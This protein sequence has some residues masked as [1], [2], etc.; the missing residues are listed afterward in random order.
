MA[1]RT[2]TWHEQDLV[3]SDST[4]KSLV[5]Q[6]RKL[7][8]IQEYQLAQRLAN[9]HHSQKLLDSH[10]LL[11]FL[12]YW[13]SS[14]SSLLTRPSPQKSYAN[15]PSSSPLNPKA[16]VFTP[17]VTSPPSQKLDPKAPVFVPTQQ[18]Q[19]PKVI[20][21]LLQ[22]LQASYDSYRVFY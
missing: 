11:A 7:T 21:G 5:S 2:S 4:L 12:P 6:N 17:K 8:H 22:Q 10:L 13:S 9:I 1:A 16:A 14:P 3:H 15:M 18:P 20:Q 19:Q